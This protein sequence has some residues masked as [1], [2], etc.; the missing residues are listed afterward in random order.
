MIESASLKDEYFIVLTLKGKVSRLA[1][2][3]QKLISEHYLF[4]HNGD[5]V[6]RTYTTTIFEV[7]GT[8]STINSF[9]DLEKI[10]KSEDPKIEML[11]IA[12]Y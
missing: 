5:I 2:R 3:V 9:R 1:N 10:I 8:D 11:E 4:N 7:I 6:N 12:G